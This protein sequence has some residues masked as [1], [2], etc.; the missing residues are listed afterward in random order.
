MKKEISDKQ[1]NFKEENLNKNKEVE[2]EKMVYRRVRSHYK[3]VFS[4]WG[5]PK[6]RVYVRAHL[7][8][9]RS[10]SSFRRKRY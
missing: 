2:E 5:R 8:R 3:K 7:R 6:K 4:G 1:K 9:V 10:S